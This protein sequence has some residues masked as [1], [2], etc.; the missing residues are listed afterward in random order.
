MAK[1]I[2]TL[3]VR[4]MVGVGAAFDLNAGLLKDSPLWVQKCGLQ[5]AHRLLQEP[6][7]LW[8]RYLLNIPR[9]IWLYLLQRIGVRSYELPPR[10]AS[11]STG[12][13]GNLSSPE[14]NTSLGEFAA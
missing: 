8:R 6:R 1:Y 3:P 14:G 9:F 2:S 7:R 10:S 12:V 13:V 4:L 11:V 5:W